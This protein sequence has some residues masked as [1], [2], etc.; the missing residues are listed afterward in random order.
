MSYR[1]TTLAHIME[2]GNCTR[3]EPSSDPDLA[4]FN[5]VTKIMLMLMK[6]SFDSP[7]NKDLPSWVEAWRLAAYSSC[8]RGVE[9]QGKRA[10]MPM[11][12]TR[13]LAGGEAQYTGMLVEWQAHGKTGGESWRMF[14]DKELADL[15][16]AMER[17]LGETE[18]V[19]VLF[20]H[21]RIQ[22]GLF[23]ALQDAKEQ[24]DCLEIPYDVSQAIAMAKVAYTNLEG[25]AD[26]E[27]ARELRGERV[28]GEVEEGS[29][30]AGGKWKHGGD[31]HG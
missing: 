18:E 27:R 20:N 31:R 8:S 6:A 3:T 26:A 1:N 23:Q 11:G 10:R 7:A 30:Q 16:A 5:L 14:L 28:Q 4:K 9:G 12:D 29:S 15:K 21:N 17:T 24:G 13:N 19:D 25:R 22:G 2:M